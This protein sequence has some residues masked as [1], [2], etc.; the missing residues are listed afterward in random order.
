MTVDSL[1][2]SLPEVLPSSGP[3]LE[4][5]QP[6][7][8]QLVHGLIV[9]MCMIKPP[10]LVTIEPHY[11]CATRVLAPRKREKG[12]W[13]TIGSMNLNHISTYSHAI[14]QTNLDIEKQ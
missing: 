7:S 9:I 14:D 2:F 1:A 10:Y 11:T 6:M 13:L 4:V 3:S 8:R 12:G 5:S